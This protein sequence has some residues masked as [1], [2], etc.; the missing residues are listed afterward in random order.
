[1]RRLLTLGMVIAIGAVSLLAYQ[2]PAQP[3]P[4]VVEVEKVKDNLFILKGGGGN[5]AVYVGATGVSVVDAKNPG[6]GKPILDKIK[7]LTPKP[8]T[9]LINTHTHGYYVSGNLY[10]PATVDVVVQENTKANM[11]K[12]PL[13]SRS[14]AGR[15]HGET[16]VQGQDDRRE[17]QRPD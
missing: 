7:E 10:F 11:E 14:T 1:M 4:M 12:M 13:S 6:L 8:I 15:G 17:R 9:L 2:P 5:T 16:D 3:G